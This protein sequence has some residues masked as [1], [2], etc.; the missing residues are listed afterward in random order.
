MSLTSKQLAGKIIST[1]LSSVSDETWT[2]L[3]KDKKCRKRKAL[4]KNIINNIRCNVLK[5]FHYKVG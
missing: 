1:S 4:F 5:F 2:A 3:K